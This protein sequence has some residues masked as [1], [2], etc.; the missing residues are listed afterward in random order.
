MLPSAPRGSNDRRGSRMKKFGIRVKRK[1]LG[2]YLLARIALPA[3][4]ARIHRLQRATRKGLLYSLM[5]SV[6]VFWTAAAPLIG[7]V[8]TLLPTSAQAA[9][10]ASCGPDAIDPGLAAATCAD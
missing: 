5:A 6:G 2:R 4:I 1:N 9:A 3:R 8:A 10:P 7:A